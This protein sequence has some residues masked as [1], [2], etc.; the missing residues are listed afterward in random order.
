MFQWD[1]GGEKQVKDRGG[2]VRQ[3]PERAAMDPFNEFRCEGSTE[4]CYSERWM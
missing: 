2:K 1:H 4:M 3:S